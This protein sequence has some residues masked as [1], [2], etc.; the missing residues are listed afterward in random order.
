M[1]SVPSFR[2]TLFFH[3]PGLVLLG[4]DQNSVLFMRAVRMSKV[5]VD[6]RAVE[7]NI[8]DAKVPEGAAFVT[9][10]PGT[11]YPD[12]PGLEVSAAVTFHWIA[13]GDA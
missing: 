2:Q 13:P 8:R 3:E 12:S 11:V 5:R 4:S 9:A 6:V 7:E 1:P 10:F